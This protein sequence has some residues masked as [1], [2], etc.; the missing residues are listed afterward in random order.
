MTEKD[1][2]DREPWSPRIDSK[3]LFINGADYERSL[4]E[5]SSP[6]DIEILDEETKDGA[7]TVSSAVPGP[8]P[9]P[10]G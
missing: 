3:R 6:A 10:E 4:G 2:K 5:G 7:E 9:K 8:I 1:E